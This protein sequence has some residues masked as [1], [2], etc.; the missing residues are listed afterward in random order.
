MDPNGMVNEV[1]K[2]SCIGSDLKEALLLLLY[3]PK[4]EQFIPMFM[5][6]YNITSIHKNKGSR[7]DLENDQGIFILTVL[8]KIL[9]KLIY[10]NKYEEL[11]VGEE[12]TDI[13]IYD[14]QKAFDALWLRTVQMTFTT[15]YQKIRGMI[16]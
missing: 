2:A 3:G 10:F 14:I 5:S 7:F 6:L 13:Q 15:P 9:D 12:F 4:T 11:G 8:K 1:F 16:N